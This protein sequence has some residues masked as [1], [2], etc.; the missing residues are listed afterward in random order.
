LSPLGTC[1]LFSESPS[2][3]PP[4]CSAVTTGFSELSLRR[5]LSRGSDISPSSQLTPLPSLAVQKPI[6]LTIYSILAQSHAKFTLVKS[7][8]LH[9]PAQLGERVNQVVVVTASISLDDSMVIIGLSNGRLWIYSLDEIGWVVCIAS[10]IP[11]K[12]NPF[13]SAL[14]SARTPRPKPECSPLDSSVS[15]DN[16]KLVDFALTDGKVAKACIFIHWPNQSKVPVNPGGWVPPCN[17]LVAA[18]IDNLVLV[19]AFEN[20]LP[21]KVEDLQNPENIVTNSRAQFCL[22]CSPTAT[23]TTLDSQPF[24]NYC[25]IAA[26]LTNGRAVIW[27]LPERH[28]IFDVCVHCT[29][30]SSIRLSP[31]GYCRSPTATPTSSPPG[32]ATITAS[33]LVA[34]TTAAEDGV[35]KAWEFPWQCTKRPPST[36]CWKLFFHIRNFC[37]FSFYPVHVDQTFLVTIISATISVDI[38]HKLFPDFF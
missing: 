25:L 1:L 23:I 26:G 7:R 37:L 6:C 35:V 14:M 10:S 18:A 38:V 8:D 32:L 24:E 31:Y 9:L 34:V 13:F 4:P 3:T 16:P 36:V 12:A 11:L 20:K 21:E 33:D 22:P 15:Y 30:V 2:S 17:P 28:K 19:W 29:P 5:R 27:S